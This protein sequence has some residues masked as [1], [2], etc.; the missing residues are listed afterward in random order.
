M[1]PAD[2]TG[3]CV[4]AWQ[5]NPYNVRDIGRATDLL[6]DRHHID[7]ELTSQKEMRATQWK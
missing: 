6:T 4:A 2:L 5:Q 1:H 3:D 7:S